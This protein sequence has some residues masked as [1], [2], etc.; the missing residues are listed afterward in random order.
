MRLAGK[1][2]PGE[3]A[4]PYQTQRA[5]ALDFAANIAAGLRILTE[6]WNQT[7]DAGLTINNGDPSKIENWFYAVWAYNSGFYPDKGDGSA[8]GVGWLNNPV[9]PIYPAN[10]QPFLDVTY[11]DAAHPQDWPYPEKVMGWAGHPVEV[12]EAPGEL[13][14]GYRP[15]WWNG[16]EETAPIHRANVKPPVTQFCDASN[17]CQPGESFTPNAPEV[18]GEPAGPCAHTNSSGQYDLKC[19]YHEPSTWKEDC[20][21]SCGNELLRFDPGYAYQEDATSYPP[22]CDLSGLPDNAMVIDDVADS[23]PSIRPNC[24]RS[25]SNAGD[26]EFHFDQAADGTYPGKIDIHQI[27][28]GFGGHFWFSHTRKADAEGG[29]L[30]A[31]GTWSFDQAVNGWARV[32]VHMPDHGAHTQQAHYQIDTGSGQFT[33]DRY[34]SQGTEA[35]K[36]VSAGVYPFSGNPR[37]RLS[38]VTQDGYGE[39]DVAWDA[40]AIQPLPDKPEHI[41]AALGDSFASGEGAGDYYTET[42]NNHGTPRWAACRRSADAW[43]RKMV[44]PGTS[45]SLGAKAD[46]FDPEAELGFVACSGALTHNVLGDTQPG[47]WS[48]PDAYGKGEGQFREIAQLKSGVLTEHTT[49]VTLSIGGNDGGFADAMGECGVGDCNSAEFYDKYKAKIQDIQ[50][51]IE[52]VLR[53][54]AERA[55]NARIAL[56]GYPKIFEA[57]SCPQKATLFTS[58]EAKRINGLAIVMRDEQVKTVQ[59]V[60]ADGIDVTFADPFERFEGHGRCYSEAWLNGVSFSAN[61]EGDFHDGDGLSTCFWWPGEDGCLSR[62]SFHPNDAGTTGYARV[63]ET[64][65]TE[66][67]YGGA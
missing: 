55:P 35:H 13:V 50:P 56:M 48:D 21:Y 64:R 7:R 31:T 61:G 44:L 42:D 65:L 57:E 5:V 9:N 24:P 17:D 67:G 12:L 10:R 66:I 52:E 53:R 54:I 34:L 40:V 60:A 38:S 26:F 63:M 36:W 16:T 47:N 58:Y 59:R 18:V 32:L 39:E 51:R 23:V 8:W 29:R 33:E 1:E 15:A 2:R 20:D 25:W 11:E 19:W 27:G 49:L 22:R 37:V 14:A 4:M 30:K 43:A 41:V 46:R 62:E 6:K 28:G 3:T 45:E